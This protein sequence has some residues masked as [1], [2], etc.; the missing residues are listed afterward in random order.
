MTHLPDNSPI[1]IAMLNFAKGME[2]LAI[3][4]AVQNAMGGVWSSD[5]DRARTALRRIP[6]DKLA[7]VALHA[8]ALASLAETI[9][10]E[11]ATE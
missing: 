11:G 9:A 5:L 8:M 10:K 7:D 6:A 1:K 4:M 2:A 3:T